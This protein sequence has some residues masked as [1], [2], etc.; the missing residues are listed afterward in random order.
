MCPAEAEMYVSPRLSDRLWVP[1]N[2]LT[3]TNCALSSEGKQPENE[4][5]YNIGV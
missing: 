3:H 4:N 2:L 5:V 1:L